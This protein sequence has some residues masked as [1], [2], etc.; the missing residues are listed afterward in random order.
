[1]GHPWPISVHFLSFQTICRIKTVDFTRIRTRIVGVKCSAWYTLTIW[2][3]L[4]PPQKIFPMSVY[5]NNFAIR[6]DI[7]IISLKFNLEKICS[8]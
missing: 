2:P 7:Q 4:R 8:T 3:L 5:L 1:M 6:I